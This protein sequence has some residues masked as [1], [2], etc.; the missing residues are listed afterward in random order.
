MIAIDP[1]GPRLASAVAWR[2]SD[3][4]MGEGP[5]ITGLLLRPAAWSH[6]S[7]SVR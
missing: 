1:L 2:D 7:E 5:S 6:E 4:L 3:A